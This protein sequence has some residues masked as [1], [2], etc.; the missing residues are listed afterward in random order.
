[1]SRRKLF[2]AIALSIGVCGASVIALL[3]ASQKKARQAFE[4]GIGLLHPPC[5]RVLALASIDAEG[6]LLAFEEAMEAGLEGAEV[7]GFYHY[8]L[9]LLDF[10]RGD[11]RMAE[12][13]LASAFRYLGEHPDLALLAAQLSHERGRF[14]NAEREIQHALRLKPAHP[15]ALAL[16]IEIAQSAGDIGKAQVH[17]HA[18][19]S[20]GCQGQALGHRE[21]LLFEARGELE[22]A[23]RKWLDLTGRAPDDLIAWINLARILHLRGKV[24]EA[25]RAY[26]KALSIESNHPHAHLGRGLVHRDLGEHKK[27]EEDFKKASS[28]APRDPKP[29]IALG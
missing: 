7:R 25:L 23:E 24:E 1:M 29:W 28:L 5:T 12:E 14:Q 6:A 15:L 26:D 4:R 22:Q 18:L 20:L 9:A 3:I 10:Q 16:A 2:L 21:A 13:E 8:A 19:R 11:L 17:L 27:A